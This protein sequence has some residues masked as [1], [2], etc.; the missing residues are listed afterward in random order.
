M[1]N[2]IVNNTK[3]KNKGNV[4]MEDDEDLDE[5][6]KEILGLQSE[7]EEDEDDLDDVDKALL[8]LGGDET[9]EENSDGA[10]FMD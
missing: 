1:S 7:M 9:E 2:Q 4:K 6:E 10:M 5:M 8:G 3:K